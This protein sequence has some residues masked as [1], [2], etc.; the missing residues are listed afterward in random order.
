MVVLLN[1]TR[2]TELMDRQEWEFWRET[3]RF[4]RI[5]GDLLASPI[6][7]HLK[8]AF[9]LPADLLCARRFLG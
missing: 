3:G 9:T 7:G 5:S 2:A 1:I 8:Q 6:F 4:L